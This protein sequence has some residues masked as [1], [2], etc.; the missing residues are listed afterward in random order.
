M[1]SIFRFSSVQAHKQEALDAE[2]TAQF[3][4]VKVQSRYET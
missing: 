1:L 2:E 3:Q 4:K